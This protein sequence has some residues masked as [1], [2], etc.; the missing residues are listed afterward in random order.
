MDVDEFKLYC[1]EQFSFLQNDFGFVLMRLPKKKDRNPFSVRYE[2]ATT[3]VII[4]GANY[5]FGI[6]VWLA[7]RGIAASNNKGYHLGDLINIRRPELM[8]SQAK[9]TDTRDVQKLQLREY[10]FALREC[11]QDVLNGDFTIF[12]ALAAAV[13]N[14]VKQWAREAK[15]KETAARKGKAPSGPKGKPAGKRKNARES[16]EESGSPVD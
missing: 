14:R 5:G 16:S 10:A 8:P 3:I 11:A 4:E 13:E 6:D 7:T 2:N 1:A 15:K 12:P 9:L